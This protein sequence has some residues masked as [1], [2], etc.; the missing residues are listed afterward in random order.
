MQTKIRLPHFFFSGIR[1]DT[2]SKNPLDNIKT[3]KFLSFPTVKNMR[4]SLINVRVGRCALCRFK[5]IIIFL[6]ACCVFYLWL[7]SETK[8][9]FRNFNRSTRCSPPNLDPFDPT[10]MQFAKKPAD[11]SCANPAEFVFVD[12]KGRLVFNTSLD[13]SHVKCAYSE[14]IRDEDKKIHFGLDHA[15][16]PPFNVPLDIF[17]VKCNNGD[18][19]VFDKVLSNIVVNQTKMTKEILDESVDNCSVIIFGLDSVSRLSAIRQLPK[20]YKFLSETM[21]AHFF[22]GHTKVNENSF[23]NLVSF[24][25]GRKF[26]NKEIP[27]LRNRVHLDDLPLIWKNFSSS[28]YVTLYAEDWPKFGTFTYDLEGFLNP[29]TDHYFV[30]FWLAKEEIDPFSF[31]DPVRFFLE[32]KDIYLTSSSMCYGNKKKHIIQMEYLERFVQNYKGKRKFGFSFLAE[33]SHEYPRFL[34][35]LDND[36][37]NSLKHLHSSGALENTVL[38][39]MS[40]H[41]SRNGAIRNTM[42]GRVED[43]MPVLAISLPEKLDEKYPHLSKIMHENSNR[44]TT[45]YDTFETL[46][47]ILQGNFGIRPQPQE[48]LPRGISLLQPIPVSRSCKDAWVLEHY[49]S[50]MEEKTVETNSDVVQMIGKAIVRNINQILFPLKD[51]CETL[52]LFR[53]L[54]SV[55]ASPGMKLVSKEAKYFGIFSSDDVPRITN[56]I[57]AIQVLPSNGTFEATVQVSPSGGIKF[58]GEITRTNRYGSQSACIHDRNRRQFCYCNQQ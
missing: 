16:I 47:D 5:K 29:P 23:P 51:K 24:L 3:A 34:Q 28:G 13:T 36:I 19:L 11:I 43:N 22:K 9:V 30:P 53:V 49:C 27:L 18:K 58:F 21:G 56:Y 48:P 41:G 39:F 1:K 35:L 57:V 7:H 6:M 20:V 40:D 10:I 54:S 33:V 31:L 4:S 42:I 2:G 32:D 14:V 46:K 8:Y 38:I 17:R 55:L 44:L 50:C 12:S 25:T 37:F 45:H 26:S 15:F 52:H